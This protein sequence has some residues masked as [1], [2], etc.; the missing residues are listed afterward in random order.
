MLIVVSANMP[1]T[2]DSQYTTGCT[3]VEGESKR[4]LSSWASPPMP[5]I[6]MWEEFSVLSAKLESAGI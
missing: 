3:T 6:L 4:P 5:P 1:H 2:T